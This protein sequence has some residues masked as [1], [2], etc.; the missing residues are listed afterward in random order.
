[1]MP[2]PTAMFAFD[3]SNQQQQQ[4]SSSQNVGNCHAQERYYAQQ[5]TSNAPASMMDMERVSL[6]DV[7]TNTEINPF[8]RHA[9]HVIP[10]S[11][12]HEHSSPSTRSDTRKKETS[13]FLPCYR[14]PTRP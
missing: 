13:R 14:L 12:R 7:T 11:N 3:L 1:M 2:S 9:S 4:D 10:T 5:G 8:H 6:L